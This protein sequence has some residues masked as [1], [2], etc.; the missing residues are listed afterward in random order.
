[1]GRRS[2]LRAYGGAPGFEYILETFVPLLRSAGFDEALVETIF[3]QNPARW[4]DF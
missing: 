1:M 4:L 2:Y 3:V